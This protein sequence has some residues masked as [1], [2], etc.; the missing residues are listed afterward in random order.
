MPIDPPLKELANP[1][2][3]GSG[4]NVVMKSC[5]YFSLSLT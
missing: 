1:A 5:G 2:R 4:Q 3:Q